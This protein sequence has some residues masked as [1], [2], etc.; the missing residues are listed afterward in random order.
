MIKLDYLC[1]YKQFKSVYSLY[2]EAATRYRR[3]LRVLRETARTR[4]TGCSTKGLSRSCPIWGGDS[5]HQDPCDLGKPGST[6]IIDR[7]DHQ[8][9]SLACFLDRAENDL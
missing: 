1:D 3:Q 7:L 8:Q 5:D 4:S 6:G 9:G 2:A